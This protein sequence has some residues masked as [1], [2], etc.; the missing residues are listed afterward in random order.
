MKQ[1]SQANKKHQFPHLFDRHNARFFTKEFRYFI[2]SQKLHGET[3]AGVDAVQ[4]HM[5][6]N[7]S[8]VR[9]RESIWNYWIF[10]SYKLMN[11]T[12][13][14]RCQIV[15]MHS[16]KLAGKKKKRKKTFRVGPVCS[17]LMGREWWPFGERQSGTVDLV[18]EGW[19]GLQ[20]DFIAAWQYFP[21]CPWYSSWYFSLD[22][23]CSI[24]HHSLDFTA[25]SICKINFLISHI[26]P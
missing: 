4:K 26:W 10:F 11:C 6:I 18:E 5:V 22:W 8:R 12:F 9:R 7:H 16:C 13:N 14:I 25:T 23:L 15:M 17:D 21:G 1:M 19:Q 3:V 2:D 24:C 20:G